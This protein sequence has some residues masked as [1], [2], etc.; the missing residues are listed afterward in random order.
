M[1]GAMR[2][3]AKSSESPH[4]TLLHKLVKAAV[5]FLLFVLASPALAKE[6]VA[7][8][9]G[10]SSYEHLRILTNPANDV[11]LVGGVL[12]KLG[13]DVQ[14]H[15]D[16]S[17][18]QMR[19]S[20]DQF[21]SVSAGSEIALVYF[22][23]HGV[24][25]EGN[26]FFAGVDAKFESE[27]DIQAESLNLDLMVRVAERSSR[28]VLAFFDAS[29]PNP[30]IETAQ[31]GDAFG[32]TRGLAPVDKPYGKSMLAFAASPGQVASQ[33]PEHSA[34]ARALAKH[35]GAPNIELL[36]LMKRI[37]QD[38]QA[39]TASL[40]TPVV[41]NNL[42]EEIYLAF[43]TDEKGLALSVQHEE[44]VFAATQR[45]NNQRAWFNYFERFPSGT[46]FD[47]ALTAS[48][49]SEL[50]DGM[51]FDDYFLLTYDL[52]APYD[53][54]RDAIARFE[55]EL[56]VS[57]EEAGQVQSRLNELGFDAGPVDG[58]LG[59]RSREAI[60]AFQKARQ[61]V[62][63]SALSSA[64]LYALGAR[65]RPVRHTQR[66]VVS[67]RIAKAYKADDIALVEV[68]E[69]VVNAVRAFEK[70]RFIY[71]FYEKRLYVGVKVGT[72]DF[73]TVRDL[74]LPHGGHLVTITSQS[75]ND[76][77]FDLVKN[78]KHLW[79]LSPDKSGADGPTIGLAQEP[80]AR[81]PDG[82]FVWVTGEPTRFS[83]WLSRKPN[84]DR[85]DA[86]FVKFM[87]CEGFTRHIYAPR[88]P[89]W[90]DSVWAGSSAVYEFE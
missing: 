39:E 50:L 72:M 33:G 8:L 56:G 80:G 5:V 87:C 53:V 28:A 16:L 3:L 64:T 71:G 73:P 70:K 22:A 89:T 62:Q 4:H 29:R 36:T 51:N 47:Q 9:V 79:F 59:S 14:V 10:N 12:E 1:N 86:H 27:F 46:F 44:V 2:T 23:G 31:S 58:Q 75:E 19:D 45:V 68:D 35:L 57:L 13:F 81:E 38:V 60:M 69:R 88:A 26:N 76:F 25:Y 49:N 77:V 63:T 41:L 37:S 48:D 34:Y 61:L 30:V 67:S 42:L 54:P 52:T 21:I 83:P 90:G 82:G 32:L 55:T 24:Q 15:T 40:Q 11:R 6:R 7:F 17:T 78:D 18:Q 20:L 65:P 43:G 84:N 85:G 66:P 74:A